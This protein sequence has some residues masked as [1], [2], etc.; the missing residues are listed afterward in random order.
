MAALMHA[1]ISYEHEYDQADEENH[2]KE[3]ENHGLASVLYVTVPRAVICQVVST[4][5]WRAPT[6]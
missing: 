1:L 4:R 5:S 2:T 6:I 3:R